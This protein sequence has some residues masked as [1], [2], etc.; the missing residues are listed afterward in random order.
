[1][2][3]FK[4]LSKAGSEVMVVPD[5]P[6]TFPVAE[7]SKVISNFGTI[8]F[9]R[10]VGDGFEAWLSKYVA[11]HSA[12]LSAR[13]DLETIE[14]Y[15]ALYNQFESTWDGIGMPTSRPLQFGFSYCPHIHNKVKLIKGM[16]YE[17][18][19]F[20]IKPYMLE[21]FRKIYREVDKFLNRVE[22]KQF[23]TMNFECLLSPEMIVV[24]HDMKRYRPRPELVS[25]FIKAKLQELLIYAFDTAFKESPPSKITIT[26]ELKDKAYD[27]RVILE[28]RVK[29]PPTVSALSQL[30]LTND[31]TMQYL[32]KHFFKC[33]VSE[34]SQLIRLEVGRGL[35]L[36]T[37]LTLDDIAYETGYYDASSFS[38]AFKK[39]YGCTPGEYKKAGRKPR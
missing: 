16:Q 10:I 28:S 17:T 7:A 31:T 36:N 11:K 34:Y 24:L 22:S 12:E 5:M 15:I 13:A 9:Q 8:R 4:I 38:G 23:A 6:T 2:V 20:H 19:D 3:E 18:L 39:R 35:L 27:A 1:M 26:K 29:N 33:T 37:S 25:G 32:F 14:M 30:V 21:P